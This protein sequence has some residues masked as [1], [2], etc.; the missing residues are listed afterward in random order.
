MVPH[1]AERCQSLGQLIDAVFPVW[2]CGTFQTFKLTICDLYTMYIYIYI[3][4]LYIYKSLLLF[5][6]RFSR[7]FHFQ[8]ALT[9]RTLGNLFS[10]KF[11]VNKSLNRDFILRSSLK[12][13]FRRQMSGTEKTAFYVTNRVMQRHDVSIFY[14]V[15]LYRFTRYNEEGYILLK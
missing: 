3:Y 13:T 1:D 12:L 7:A 11:C 14:S 5:S 4:L 8:S 10:W 6:N 9:L 15:I 2:T